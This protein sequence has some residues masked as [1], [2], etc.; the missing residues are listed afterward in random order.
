MIAQGHVFPGREIQDQPVVMTVLRHMGDARSAARLA[1]GPLARQ[2]QFSALHGDPA[3]AARHAAKSRQ[4]FRLPIARHPGNAKDFPRAD[5]KADPFQPLH[6]VIV[7]HAQVLHR[8]NH[9]AGRGRGLG[10]L[11]QNLAA[12]HQ[13]GQRLGAGLG[14]F[15]RGHHRAAPHDADI[16]GRLHD[17]AQLV[18]DEDHRLALIF[19]P[20]QDAKQMVRLIRGQNPGRLVQ[21]QD[22]GLA[23]QRLEDLHPLLMAHRQ[24]FDQGIRIDVQLV[25]PRQ[26]RQR[27]ARP[28]QRG[29]QHRAILGPQD[30]VFQYGEILHQLEM[31]E[32]HADPGANGALAVGDGGEFAI[33]KDLTGIGFVKAVE[34]RHQRRLARAVLTDD[35][36]DGAFR[37]GNVDVFVGLNRTEGFGN[38]LQL[39][40]VLGVAHAHL[41]PVWKSKARP[42]WRG[43]GNWPLVKCAAPDGSGAA[44]MHVRRS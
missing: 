6:P 17:L 15:H 4:Q 37:H 42:L 22:I 13:L 7:L 26:I 8:Q 5:V 25:L 1:V 27:L 14:G 33:H 12:H 21:N 41:S 32:H 43:F 23:I 2:G 29:V 44:R 35:A 20:P 40:R 16:V 34:D 11:Q 9:I 39:N 31:L 24:I 28:R 30:H 38:A 3:G 19:Q 36:V 18:G 10:H